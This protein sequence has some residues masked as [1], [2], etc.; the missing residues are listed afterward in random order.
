MW[1]VA[2]VA[3]IFILQAVGHP[4]W[5]GDRLA[6]DVP[7]LELANSCEPVE[8][9]IAVMP[10]R[11][12]MMQAVIP[13]TWYWGAARLVEAALLGVIVLAYNWP[14]GAPITQGM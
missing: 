8:P 14:N 5:C 11:P 1:C 9:R 6:K 12:S 10:V 4:L 7:R 13:F 3:P 2:T